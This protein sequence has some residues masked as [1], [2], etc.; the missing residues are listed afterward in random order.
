[1]ADISAAKFRARDALNHEPEMKEV[2]VARWMFY[3]EGGELHSGYTSK[4]AAEL[5]YDT[6]TDEAQKSLALVEM[7]GTFLRPI[8]QRRM[9]LKMEDDLKH[10]GQYIALNSPDTPKQG[11]R[12]FAEW[13]E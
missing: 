8:R 4:E 9:E 6:L 5:W 10:F 3:K 13:Q 1:M 7:T 11:V 2:R 12:I